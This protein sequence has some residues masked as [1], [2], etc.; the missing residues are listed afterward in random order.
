MDSRGKSSH[1]RNIFT[2][3]P[4]CYQLRRTK[5]RENSKKHIPANEKETLKS[6]ENTEDIIITK[7]HKAQ[8]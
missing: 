6:L 8:L 3:L 2:S 5:T 1:K 7:V 4:I